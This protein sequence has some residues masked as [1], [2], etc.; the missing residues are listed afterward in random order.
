VF[1]T[2][3]CYWV[4]GGEAAQFGLNTSMFLVDVLFIKN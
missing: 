1:V 3:S 4:S 2:G